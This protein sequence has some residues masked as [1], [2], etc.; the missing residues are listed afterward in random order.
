MCAGGLFAH[1]LLGFLLVPT[2]QRNPQ[3]EATPSEAH[4]YFHIFVMS[5]RVRR[6]LLLVSLNKRL[7]VFIAYFGGHTMV[8]CLCEVLVTHNH[9][10]R[11]FIFL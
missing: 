10:D 4:N 9:F 11:V 3:L 5:S 7:V 2:P 8:V 6:L 1:L